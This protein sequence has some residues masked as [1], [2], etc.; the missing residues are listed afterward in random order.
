MTAEYQ[1]SITYKIYFQVEIHPRDIPS[2]VEVTF[3]MVKVGVK[4]RVGMS[5]G[6]QIALTIVHSSVFFYIAGVK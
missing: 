5:Q 3:K 4:F 1:L 2:P 6:F